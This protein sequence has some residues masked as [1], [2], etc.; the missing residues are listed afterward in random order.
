MAPAGTQWLLNTALAAKSL[1]TKTIETRTVS[2]ESNSANALQRINLRRCRQWFG[3]CLFH[4]D[5]VPRASM[6]RATKRAYTLA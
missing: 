6:G 2:A 3:C 4:G 1:G 5:N